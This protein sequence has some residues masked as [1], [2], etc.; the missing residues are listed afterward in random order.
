M[1]RFVALAAAALVLTGPAPAA[2]PVNLTE[3]VGAD[4]R[5]KATVDLDVKGEL[6]FV[7]DG[8]KEAARLEAKARHAFTERTLAV[9]DGMPSSTARW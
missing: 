3:K 6:L 7:V 5:S 8:K 9:A 4:V 2:D 1:T